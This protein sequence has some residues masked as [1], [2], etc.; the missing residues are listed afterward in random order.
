MGVLFVVTGI[1]AFAWPGRTFLVLAHLVAWFLL[2]K[3]TLDIFIAFATRP[4][5][6]WWARLVA[7]ILGIVIAFWAAGY[8]GRSAV[9][10]VLWIGI[11]AL[12]RGVMELVLAFQLKGM[13]KAPVAG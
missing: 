1:L 8:G 12:T 2:F 3:G 7:G 13:R 6:L 10:L 4:A 5:E 9:L 11:A